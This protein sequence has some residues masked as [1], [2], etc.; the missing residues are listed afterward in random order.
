MKE[1]AQKSVPL[2]TKNFI[3]ITIINFLVFFGFQML[4]PTFPVYVKNLG[5]KDSII[6]LVTGIFTVSALVARPLSGR[7]LDK[8]GRKGVFIAGMG[9]SILAV[10]SYGWISTIGLILLFR[11]IHGFGWGASSTASST[12]ASDNIPRE[13]FGEGM[14]YF[15]LASSFAMAVA[16]A[17]GLYVV[18]KYSFHILFFVSAGLAILG[19]LLAF[20]LKYQKVEKQE[21]PKV[22]AA[23]YEKS[24]IRPSIVI[25]FVCITYGSLT[26]FLPLY[27]AQRGIQNI[28]LFF[29]VFAVSLLVSRPV[30]GKII[31]RFGFDFAVIPGLSCILIAMVLLSQA[32]V[33]PVFLVVAFIYGTG[34][35]AVQ[36]SLQT[37]AVV[38]TPP[39]RLGAANATFLTGFDSGIG[40]GAI[41]L[42]AVASAVGYSQMYLWAV[43]SL[44]IA[45]ILYFLVARKGRNP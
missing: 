31:D 9:I 8:I 18:S 2:W 41:I 16:P 19:F 26:S 1:Q 4:L 17:V 38:N 23:L 10:L 30:F 28:G 29:T 20:T 14:G 12:V 44:I 21:Q 15:S 11:L 7:V 43:V 40:L 22:K 36:S 37:M 6:G 3:L 42:G 25:F 13:R 34:F 33:L 32:S 24:S 39:H 45:F 27:A 5:G 35:G